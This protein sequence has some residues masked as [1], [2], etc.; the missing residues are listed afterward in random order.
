MAS[1]DRQRIGFEAAPAKALVARRRLWQEGNPLAREPAAQGND[2][3]GE[4]PNTASETDGAHAQL[5]AAGIEQVVEAPGQHRSATEAEQRVEPEDSRALKIVSGQLRPQ[6][7]V[8]QVVAGVKQLEHARAA[9]QPERQQPLGTRSAVAKQRD[10][11]AAVIQQRRRRQI[12]K[13]QR[14]AQRQ[15]REVDERVPAPEPAAMVVREIADERVRDRIE[16]NGQGN[17]E[18]GQSARQAEADG[19]DDEAKAAERPVR[20]PFRSAAHR[21][22]EFRCSR[23]RPLPARLRFC[24][25]CPLFRAA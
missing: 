16:D 11:R 9:E 6:R 10:R 3:H 1:E 17:S 5:R 8:R 22:A 23:Q 20:R 12:H 24:H 14:R 18:P 15:G 2:H 25:R 4:Q 19:V 21:I 13:Q 7:Q